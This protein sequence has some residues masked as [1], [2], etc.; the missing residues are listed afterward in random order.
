MSGQ[1]EDDWQALDDLREARVR[2]LGTRNPRCCVAGCGERDPFAL[3]GTDPNI[4]CRE[5]S[6][7][8]RGRGWTEAHHIS[9]RA[10]DPG[11][12]SIPANDHAVLSAYQSLWP[13]DTLRNPDQSPLL[14][15]AA[16]LQGWLDILRLVIERTAG[17][18]PPFLRWLDGVLL[19]VIGEHWWIVIGW[20][21]W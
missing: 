6:A 11:T 4:I 12:V 10:N 3:T 18:I 2:A 7:D 1:F 16:E 21:G 5:H 13:R 19:T 17:R 8:R 14:K 9:G 15:A 20:A